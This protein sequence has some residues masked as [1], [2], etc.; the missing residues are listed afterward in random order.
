M[1]V[2]EHRGEKRATQ[3]PFVEAYCNRASDC[4]MA[5][6]GKRGSRMHCTH[7]VDASLPWS[8]LFEINTWKPLFNSMMARTSNESEPLIER[9]AEQRTIK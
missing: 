1:R 4:S 5:L 2:G 9:H 6:A 7:P 8:P 3:Q